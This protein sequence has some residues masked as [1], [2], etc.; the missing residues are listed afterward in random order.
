LNAFR[1]PSSQALKLNTLNI[2]KFVTKKIQTEIYRKDNQNNIKYKKIQ[3]L[4]IFKKLKYSN[5]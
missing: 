1:I 3:I 4:K 5:A 2:A